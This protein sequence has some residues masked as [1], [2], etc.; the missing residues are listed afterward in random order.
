MNQQQVTA[1]QHLVAQQTIG[2]ALNENISHARQVS[3]T[4][5]EATKAQFFESGNWNSFLITFFINIFDF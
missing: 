3:H 4:K 1:Q 2:A 5:S